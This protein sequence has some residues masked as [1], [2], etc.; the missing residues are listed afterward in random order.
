MPAV[1]WGKQMRILRRIA[2]LGQTARTDG[3][4][5]KLRADTRGNTLAMAGAALVPIAGMIGSG[6]DMSRAYMAQAKLQNACDAA[7]LAA[8]RIMSGNDFTSEVQSEGERFFDFNFPSDTMNAQ[9][10]VRTVAQHPTAPSTVTVTSTADIPTTIMGLFGNEE[11]PISVEC[12]AN[13]DYGNNDVLVVLD[14]T[15]S[16]N[17]TPS[18][19]GYTTKIQRL[20][21][22]AIGLYRA[23]SGAS[24]TRTRYGVIP[25]SMTVNV[26]RQLRNRDILRNTYYQKRIY[27]SDGDFAGYALSAVHINDTSY[28]DDTTGKGIRNWRQSGNACVEERPSIGNPDHEIEIDLT[29]SQD[30]IDLIASNSS[31]RARQWG[32]YDPNEQDASNYAVCPAEASKLQ[33]Y[34]SESAFQTAIN[35]ATS[36]VS[37]NTYH[38][39]GIMWGARFL[40]QTGM[41]ALNNPAEWQGVPVSQHIVFLTDGMMDSHNTAYSSY[42][43]ERY[44]DRVPGTGAQEA[45]H[46]QRFHAAC[47][48]AKSMGMTI[49]VI[50]LDVTSSSD[51]EPCATSSGHFFESD[52]S[53][54]EDVFV[55]IGQGIGRLRLTQ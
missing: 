50:A 21:T 55:T 18:T 17:R 22:G 6:L 30:D 34:A 3:F 38:D 31:D 26:G 44:D 25:Y 43:V 15:G 52:G 27:D 10:V 46:I 45:Q 29:V 41:F 53:D 1:N 24:N 19:G 40:S 48:A 37:G 35:N 8:R 11:I 2:L 32:R 7:A 20:R 42:G 9:N 28:A 54:L 33:S 23:L 5:H 4:L 49:W 16:M 51:I 47:N 14:V 36:V 39:V 12:D 13:Q